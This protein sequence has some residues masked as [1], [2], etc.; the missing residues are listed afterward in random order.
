MC[1]NGYLSNVYGLPDKLKL[2]HYMQYHL[3]H[4][5]FGRAYDHSL[6][7]LHINLL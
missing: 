2:L 4:G 5:A 7:L 3:V 6:V 1:E